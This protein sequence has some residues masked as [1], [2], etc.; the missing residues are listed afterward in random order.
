[1]NKVTNIFSADPQ[2]FVITKFDCTLLVNWLVC[3]SETYS[4]T[5]VTKSR[6]A[7]A[8]RRKPEGESRKAKA[9]V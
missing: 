1:M 6:K 8:G 4:G 5:W 7:K 9:V 2:E 3:S